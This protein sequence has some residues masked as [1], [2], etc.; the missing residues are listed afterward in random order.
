M[1]NR[2]V[3]HI[4]I[5]NTKPSYYLKKGLNLHTLQGYIILLIEMMSH[6]TWVTRLIKGLQLL[7]VYP[8]W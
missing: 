8:N 2:I 6:K 7:K 1:S 3:I 5:C 4:I